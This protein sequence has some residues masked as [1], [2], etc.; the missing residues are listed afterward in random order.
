M[1]PRRLGKRNAK[2]TCFI[3]DLD[4]W[5]QE[6][7]DIITRILATDIRNPWKSIQQEIENLYGI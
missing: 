4:D 6:E 2:R 7:D 1:E 3:P 5:T